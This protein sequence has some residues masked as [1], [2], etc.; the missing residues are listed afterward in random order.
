MVRVQMC[1]GSDDDTYVDVDGTIGDEVEAAVRS[2]DGDDDGC[3]GPG[4][5]EPSDDAEEVAISSMVER[6]QQEKGN[7]DESEEYMKEE[8]EPEETEHGAQ[9]KSEGPW[10]SSPTMAP[11]PQPEDF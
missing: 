5:L 7:E 3:T 6:A 2:V 11:V 8:L 4:P 10:E 1:M 9:D